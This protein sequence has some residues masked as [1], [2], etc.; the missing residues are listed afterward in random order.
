MLNK[1]KHLTIGAK[2]IGSFVF[3]LNLWNDSANECCKSQS[4][5]ANK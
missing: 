4:R 1:I 2:V 5:R 3:I